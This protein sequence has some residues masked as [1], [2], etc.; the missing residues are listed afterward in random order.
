M[1]N[2]IIETLTKAHFNKDFIEYIRSEFPDDFT[3]LIEEPYKYDFPDNPLLDLSVKDKVFTLIYELIPLKKFFDSRNIP[4]RIFY[5]SLD[6]ISYRINRYYEINGEYGV[7]DRDALWLRFIYKGEIFDLGSL[8][9]QK[10]HFSNAEIE[11]QDYDYMPF[12]D[13]M[14]KRFPEGEPIINVHIQTDADL[15]PEKIDESF[16]LAHDFFTTYFPE[17]KYTVFTCRTWMLYP[18]TQD[19]LPPDSNITSF[20]NRFEI[21]ATNQNTKQALDRIYET[22]DMAEIE[23][24]EKSSSLAEVAYKNLDKLG[25]AAGVIP[26]ME[27]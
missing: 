15:R 5:D 18:P 14:K 9:F 24:M 7:T 8:R 10:F 2:K 22:S 13:E 19:L 23:K 21:I 26:R 12:S 1:K 20:A 27:S 25:V 6:D 17:H 16:K 3:P 4:D 11:R